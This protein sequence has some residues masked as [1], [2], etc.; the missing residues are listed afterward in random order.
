M[1]YNAAVKLD[2]QRR[3]NLKITIVGYCGHEIWFVY[4]CP[5][6]VAAYM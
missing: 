4:T 1:S 6:H 3:E 5:G 2:F